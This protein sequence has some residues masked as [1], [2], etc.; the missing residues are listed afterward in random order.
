MLIF[1]QTA[2]SHLNIETVAV[3]TLYAIMGA[4]LLMAAYKVFDI[5]NPLDFDKEI[6][7]NNISL[8][9]MIAGFF[10]SMALIIAAAI[11]G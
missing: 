4:I 10:L 3:T 6:A 8:S 7:N 5:I 1:A 2:V 11:F 9:I